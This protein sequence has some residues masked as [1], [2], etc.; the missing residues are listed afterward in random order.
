M[1]ASG[2]RRGRGLSEEEAQ[3][4]ETVARAVKPLR[5]RAVKTENARPVAARAAAAAQAKSVKTPDATVAPKSVAKP[6]PRPPAATL[7]RR[8]RQKL[9]RGRENIDARIDLH[10]MTQAEAHAV[11]SYFLRRVQRDGAR[12]V[13]VVTGKGGRGGAGA[14][15]GVLRRQVPQW[16][17]LPEFREVVVGFDVAGIGHGG[18]GALYVQIRKAR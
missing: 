11:L 13:I 4:W 12:F 3:L 9:G 16:L 8:T 18:D 5:K 6:A 10:G 14:E 7:D 2:G 1:S 17:G 15:R